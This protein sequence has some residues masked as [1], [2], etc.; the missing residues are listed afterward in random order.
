M[1]D[2]KLYA[3]Y[4]KKDI[5]YYLNAIERDRNGSTYFFNVYAFFFGIFWFM[6]RKMYRE[7]C[8]I[9]LVIVVEGY[10][11]DKFTASMS[12]TAIKV[13]SRISTIAIGI[14]VSMLANAIY[15]RKAENVIGKAKQELTDQEVLISH[16]QQKG[17][18]SYRFLIIV[19]I[20]IVGI[21]CYF[22]NLN[23]KG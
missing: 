16:L 14:I 17:G 18:V 10:L 7:S 5:D 4:F 1:E 22:Y 9:I 12:E 21:I 23:N 11:E 15:I 13:V 8:I 6:Y 19:L 20:V 2:D 3:A